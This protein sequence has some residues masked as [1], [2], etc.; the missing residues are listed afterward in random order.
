MSVVASIDPLSY[1]VDGLR[2]ALIGLS[3]FGAATDLAVLA[4]LSM[5]LL[6]IGGYLFSRIQL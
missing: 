5:L 1:G 2:S 3:H 6:A 4:A